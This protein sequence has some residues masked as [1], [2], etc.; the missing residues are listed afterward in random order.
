M[1]KEGANRT[2]PL[3]QLTVQLQEIA[4]AY[5]MVIRIDM[6]HWLARRPMHLPV[7]FVLYVIISQ[8]G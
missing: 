1:K 3:M 2:F 6:D 8:C 4:P 7:I 5:I